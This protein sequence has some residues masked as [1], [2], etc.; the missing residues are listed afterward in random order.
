MNYSR[1][2]RGA[3]SLQQWA[4]SLFS[5]SPSAEK[6]RKVRTLSI[7]RSESGQEGHGQRSR[8]RRPTF[9][10]TSCHL[11]ATGIAGATHPWSTR[12]RWP[13][14]PGAAAQPQVTS[15]PEGGHL[16]DT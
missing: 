16:Q 3:F 15:A 2:A 1:Q 8:Q 6:T 12:L 14:L 4:I 7:K 10:A 13:W 11:K 9:G 5:T